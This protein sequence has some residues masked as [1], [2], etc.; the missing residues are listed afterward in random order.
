MNTCKKANSKTIKQFKALKGMP[1]I[2]EKGISIDTTHSEANTFKATPE[3]VM[4]H[5]AKKIFKTA[6]RRRGKTKPY[7]PLSAMAYRIDQERF[8][9]NKGFNGD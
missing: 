1:C 9:Y 2:Y 4:K 3:R 6:Q 8:S 5:L 7:I